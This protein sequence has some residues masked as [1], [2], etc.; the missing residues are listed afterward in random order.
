MREKKWQES[1]DINKTYQLTLWTIVEEV[2]KENLFFKEKK[3]EKWGCM[4]SL[5]NLENIEVMST[6]ADIYAIINLIQWGESLDL[7]YKLTPEWPAHHSDSLNMKD[8][9]FLQTKSERSKKFLISSMSIVQ[10]LSAQKVLFQG[11]RPP[12]IS[13]LF[14][15]RSY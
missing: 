4:H 3:K 5:G 6:A 12:I 10:A 14:G 9:E 15:S 7:T 8:P 1:Q 11:R 13:E 2:E